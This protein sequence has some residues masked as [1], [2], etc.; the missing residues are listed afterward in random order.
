MLGEDDVP[1]PPVRGIRL[2]ADECL[3]LQLVGHRGEERPF[4][5]QPLAWLRLGMLPVS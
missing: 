2:P 4:T 3:V 5:T 1:L